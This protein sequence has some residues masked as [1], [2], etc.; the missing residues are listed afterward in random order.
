[1]LIFRKGLFFAVFGTLLLT[2]GAFIIV[3]CTKETT[4]QPSLG[5]ASWHEVGSPGEPAF[6]HSWTNYDALT[7]STCAFRKDGQNF[8]YLKGT[9]AG[10]AERTVVF[11]LPAGYR[12]SKLVEFNPYGGAVNS[13]IGIDTNGNVIKGPNFNTFAC[14]DG[15]VFYAEK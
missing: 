15:I 5:D 8:V 9:I 7:Y 4:T 6:Q 12:P 1:M 14:L 10:G 3:G 2:A 13:A 11:G